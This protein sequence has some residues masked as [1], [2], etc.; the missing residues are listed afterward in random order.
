MS[1]RG[2]KIGAKMPIHD[3]IR[4]DSQL[5]ETD[6]RLLQAVNFPKQLK[7]N[8][9]VQKRIKKQKVRNQWTHKTSLS[10]EDIIYVQMSRKVGEYQIGMF[11]ESQQLAQDLQDGKIDLKSMS[12][13][14]RNKVESAADI[15]SPR[16]RQDYY[17]D[18]NNIQ[19]EMETLLSMFSAP[20]PTPSM[21]PPANIEITKEEAKEEATIKGLANKHKKKAREMYQDQKMSA[22]EISEE[23]GVDVQ[24][25]ILYLQSLEN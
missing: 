25:V 7:F 24:R 9:V 17:I 11:G 3:W 8:Q 20:K 19:Q 15:M 23:L 22:K 13:L 14:E 4:D 16:A 18:G 12:Q 21:Q 5:S 1:F 10:Y 2:N 6:L